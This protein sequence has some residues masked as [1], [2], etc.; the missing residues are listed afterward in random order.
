MSNRKE[1]EL[2]TTDAND[3]QKKETQKNLPRGLNK[4]GNQKKR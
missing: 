4:R 3:T 1:S 2:R